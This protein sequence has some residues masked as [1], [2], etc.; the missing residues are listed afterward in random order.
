MD[1]YQVIISRRST[2]DYLSKKV[3]NKIIAEII[4]AASWAPS[5]NNS[6]PWFF[7]AVSNREIINKMRKA[8]IESDPKNRWLKNYGAFFNAPCIIS[9][10]IDTN[11]RWYHSKNPAKVD[12]IDDV[13]DN[14]DYFSVAAAIQNL[15]L[16]AHALKIGSCW[17][18]TSK[19]YR[20]RLEKILKIKKPYKLAANITLGYYRK[21]PA[22]PPRKPLKDIYSLFD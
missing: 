20:E 1:T 6:Q 15:L 14:P 10:A 21:T 11:K 3:P 13:L 18:K 7:Y 9:V 8:V 17:C 22:V 2:R 12:S 4:K 19:K 5:G 16:A